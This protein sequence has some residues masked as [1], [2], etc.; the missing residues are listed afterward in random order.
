M[1]RVSFLQNLTRSKELVP[2]LKQSE[3]VE[4]CRQVGITEQTFY[5]WKASAWGWRST[6]CGSSSGQVQNAK[7]KKLVAELNLDKVMLQGR[8][9]AENRG[10]LRASG[11]VSSCVESQGQI[12]LACGKDGGEDSTSRNEVNTE[13]ATTIVALRS[14]L[15][16]PATLLSGAPWSGSFILLAAS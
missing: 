6:R 14:C 3:A 2:V 13:L 16:F 10:P 11:V 4:V 15:S 8:D 5:H 7:L 9:N 12:T 1:L